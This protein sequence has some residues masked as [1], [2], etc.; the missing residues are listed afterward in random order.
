MKKIFAIL[1][2]ALL[3][4]NYVM[5][6][7]VDIT[8][9]AEAELTIAVSPANSGYVTVKETS[10]QDYSG[11]ESWER[12]SATNKTSVPK[13][14]TVS[15][16]FLGGGSGSVSATANV[17]G[18]VKQDIGYDFFGFGTTASDVDKGRGNNK[19]NSVYEYVVS[20]ECTCTVV[21]ILG[22]VIGQSL[23]ASDIKSESIYAIF[24]P[25]IA[26]GE[27]VDGQMDYSKYIQSGD[28]KIV[29]N[30][31]Q[32]VTVERTIHLYNATDYAVTT[33]E[34][35]NVKFKLSKAPATSGEDNVTL[36]IQVLPGATNGEK[37]SITFTS[38]NNGATATINVTVEAPPTITFD[39]PTV[40]GCGYQAVQQNISGVTYK[41]GKK[42][43]EY[44]AE[45][46]TV[47]VKNQ[48]DKQFVLTAYP[49]A[50][51]RF[52]RWKITNGDDVKYLYKESEQ[53]YEAK[54]D[55]HITA[56]FVTTDYAIFMVKDDNGSEIL[57]NNL[58]GACDEASRKNNKIV[59]VKQSGKVKA[60]N[61]TIPFGVTLLVPGD[62]AN[63][64]LTQTSSGAGSSMYLTGTLPSLHECKKYISLD[65]GTNITVNGAICV[66][67]KLG[68][69]MG[70][71]GV[72][73]DHGK[74]IMGTNSQ[75]VLES[76]SKLFAYG[77]I[78]G[79]GQVTA[80]SGANLYECVQIRDWRGGSA[81][82]SIVGMNG[83]GDGTKVFPFGQYYVQ[84]IETN[85]VLNHGATA[86]ISTA[87]NM[88]G[89]GLIPLNVP[90]IRP[91]VSGVSGM[92]CMQS[93]A[94]VK[95]WY[96]SEKDQL[97]IEF[98][99]DNIIDQMVLP[100]SIKILIEMDL[101]ISS[102]DYVLPFNSNMSFNLRDA[103]LV[104]KK[105]VLFF[106]GTIIDIDANSTLTI[107]KNMYLYDLDQFP[108]EE[109]KTFFFQAPTDMN[110]LP[111]TWTSTGI[112]PTRTR[113][114]T[115][116]TII[117]DGQVVV[118]GALY[119]TSGG[120]NITSHEGGKVVYNAVG[121]SRTTNQKWQ[122]PNASDN[123][124]VSNIT[125][126]I[127]NAKLHNDITKYSGDEYVTV[128]GTGT[129]TYDAT[130]GRWASDAE[131]G[132]SET[133]VPTFEM[134]KHA[135][136]TNTLSGE[137][138]CTFYKPNNVSFNTN[139][140]NVVKTSG[141]NFTIGTW[142]LKS[143]GKLYIP[144]TYTQQNKHGNYEAVFTLTDNHEKLDLNTPI[145]VTAIE[146]YQ[147]VFTTPEEFQIS[148]TVNV[149]KSPIPTISISPEKDNIAEQVTNEFMSWS[150]QLENEDGTAYQGSEFTFEYGTGMALLSNAKVTFTPNSVG[151]K[152]A[153][154]HLIATYDEDKNAE[155]PN[156]VAFQEITLIGNASLNP[157][158]LAFEEFTT[159]FVGDTRTL[160]ADMGNHANSTTQLTYDGTYA[161]IDIAQNKI[162]ANKAGTITV[163]ATQTATGSHESADKSIKITIYPTEQWNW[164]NLYYGSTHTNPVT[165][166]AASWT[167][168]L[169][170]DNSNEVKALV[171]LRQDES[172]NYIVTIGEPANVS[173]TL[174]AKFTF[175]SGGHTSTYTATLS[176]LRHLPACVDNQA[177]YNAVEYGRGHQ[178]ETNFIKNV[179]FDDADDCLSFTSHTAETSIWTMQFLG[180][181][182]KITFT[183]SGSR[184]WHFEESADALSWADVDGVGPRDLVS[185]QEV[186]LPLKP[187]TRFVRITYS[188]GEDN[189]GTLKNLCVTKLAISAS[190]NKLYLP[191]SD[192]LSKTIKLTHVQNTKPAISVLP[193]EGLNYIVSDPVSRDGVYETTVTLSATVPQEY[194]LTA[195]E[196]GAEA[197]VTVV[198]Y[199]FPQGLPIKS[200][201]WTGGK[202]E[203]YYF[204]AVE[205]SYAA[206][207]A[208][209]N[210]IVLQ[211]PSADHK[212]R[213]ITFAFEGG[214]S[215]VSFTFSAE[216]N[217]SEWKIEESVDGTESS[218]RRATGTC[219][220]NE[221][222]LIQE[223]DYTT[224]YVRLTY[225]GGQSWV[226]RY[227]TNLVIEGYPKV[228]ITP[229][230]LELNETDKEKT[231]VITAINLQNINLQ[232][233][234]DNFTL[235]H[236]S[237]NP[238]KSISLTQ[239]SGLYPDALG[240]NK[241]GDITITVNWVG[242]SIV[243]AGEI[244]I[245]NPDDNNA[246]LGTVQLLGAKSAITLD[247]ADKTGIWT[248]VPDGRAEGRPTSTEYTLEGKQFAAY[249]YRPIDVSNAFLQDASRAA[250]FD[251]LFVYGET[252]TTDGRTTITTPTQ[253]S[254]SN[255]Q[256]PYYIYKK[257]VDGISYEFVEAVENANSP[258]KTKLN[259][260]DAATTTDDEG[261]TYYSIKP[262]TGRTEMS[263]YVTGFCPYATTGYTKYDEG[264]WYIQGNA[265]QH[266]HLYLEDCHIYSRNKTEDG[267]NFVGRQGSAFTEGYVR[268]S[269][270]VFVFE[271][272]TKSE[273][274]AE[275][276]AFHVSIHTRGDNVL[277]SNYGSFFNLMGDLRAFQVSSPIQVHL[278]SD[279]YVNSSKVT[280]NFDDVWQVANT[281][282]EELDYIRTNGFLSLQ[283]Q[284]NNAP[285]IDLGNE[286]TTVNFR[287]GRI[288]LQNA[289]IVSTN[290]KTTLAISH[291]SG[292]MGAVGLNLHLAYGMGTDATGGT[293]KFY[294]GTT[295]VISMTVPEEYRGYYLMDT[296]ETGA[297]TAT[298][299][300]LRCPKQTYVYGGSHGMLRA[301]RSVTSRGG[302]PTDGPDGKALGKYE[303]TLITPEEGTRDEIK[304]N[305]LAIIR[306][307][308]NTGLKAYYENAPGYLNET[309]GLQSVAPIENKLYFWIPE[310]YG[311]DVTPERDATLTTWRTCM[312]EISASYAGKTAG[313]G[314][315]LEIE[316]DEVV[317][318]LLYCQIDKNIHDVI[319]KTERRTVTEWVDEDEDGE[320]DPGEEKSVEKDVH[321]YEAMVKDPTGQL[322]DDY[323]SIRPTEVGSELQNAVTNNS[324]Y[325][326]TDRVYYITTATADTWMNFTAP[327]DVE[328]IYVMETYDEA[329]IV[330]Y[331][332]N[333]DPGDES[334]YSMTAKFQA[335]HNADFAA[336]FAMAMALGSD[337]PFEHIYNQYIEW[338]MLQDQYTGSVENYTTRGMT[339]LVHYDGTN[340][341]TSHFYLYEN[342]TTAD[343][344]TQDVSTFQTQWEI[345]PEKSNRKLLEKGNTYSMLFPYALGVDMQSE[346]NFWDYWTGKFLIFESTLGSQT[347]PH[348]IDGSDEA[349]QELSA[350]VEE[351]HAKLSGNK[352]LAQFNTEREDVYLYNI[353]RRGREQYVQNEKEDV[354][355][356]S[357]NADLQVFPTIEPTTTFLIVNL[358]DDG[359]GQN[360][361]PAR[362]I[363]RTGQIIYDTTGEGNGTITGGNIPTVGGG[364]DLFITKTTIGINI[365]VA[366]PQQVRVIS[367]T[368]AVLYSGMVQTSVDVAIPTTG[369]YVVTG[370][371]EAQ[372]ILY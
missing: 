304:D 122:D 244:T 370:E 247:D 157:N 366:A 371:N 190:T 351:N 299:S 158:N 317:K 17:Y 81:T 194:T 354:Y 259:F 217:L 256:T 151:E 199:T 124:Q 133:V 294:D 26:I 88:T 361:A 323:F 312:T 77:Y 221:T 130:Q 56:E 39:P 290:Y 34:T 54:N 75:I 167:L 164:S 206:W 58:Q 308:P 48:D 76:G 281:T 276:E 350:S 293:V 32:T 335:E 316:S 306:N 94:T 193:A 202:Q 22:S 268:G 218:W 28:I 232:V 287:G 292:T 211:N 213:S 16:N 41:L 201:D 311:Y 228:V 19:E 97:Y 25:I 321:V 233:D 278:A 272:L 87:V 139:D 349:L 227:V 252:T 79:S 187:T 210:R 243:N 49:S 170:D 153:V 241:V 279:K 154:L 93:N 325:E 329:K 231:F 284:V 184:K 13:S 148:S 147:P 238:A 239:S 216:I 303:Y 271:C 160:F 265:G 314:G 340:F 171:D 332:A 337:K 298:T 347:A 85:L 331:F 20:T 69:E 266:V 38:K 82:T 275:A 174:T 55:D 30:P 277:K 356:E 37:A 367:S 269:G 338:A 262:A 348:E 144:I 134:K 112:A 47:V 109:G 27:L 330:E 51:H 71:N 295:S 339:P 136:S 99:G 59:Y 341:P 315:D 101:T 121:N 220:V 357:T 248:G 336:F 254:G 291:R 57:F 372:K 188:A 172:G 237:S 226:E 74:I 253:E 162:T 355:D 261:H 72:P 156:L 223:L 198:A 282:K 18:Y 177:R 111:L 260:A 65:E 219:T 230:E 328:N 179:V 185:D 4:V 255:A 333:V 264:V 118:K 342:K 52:Y 196:N 204:Y 205:S 309:Y 168:A 310:N 95:K 224:R 257:G 140:F 175:T 273:N 42:L 240:V 318:Y 116:A 36:T 192:G 1:V 222:S 33:Q 235:K 280:L 149:A 181:P 250:I 165:T 319:S 258:T 263:I 90:F 200:S 285:S 104:T 12:I 352:S 297:E 146:N 189:V 126:N 197:D 135:T 346:R 129:Y 322:G 142:E 10:L 137:I 86:Y 327:F 178:Y 105:D 89:A 106:P 3:S 23:S 113:P 251:Y 70:F 29:S 9:T 334:K 78:T 343:W 141:D 270:G 84:N 114:T 274:I 203:Y 150:Y 15:S 320:I 301:C 288:E 120:A 186:S 159:M 110:I 326:V 300:C 143:D 180:T 61:Y 138:V 344:E 313:I 209:N 215:I 125:I 67:A 359:S 73:F 11:Y 83:Q 40:D 80:N 324:S 35:S 127:T 166:N 45:S 245:T 63:T 96:D 183:P 283:K 131:A 155:T 60:E 103:N 353:P 212:D 14:K 246:V 7:S 360:L 43:A 50:N 289:A 53:P 364:N 305:G 123:T 302:A 362:R 365:A 21:F 46:K 296:D 117:V 208:T 107:E 369:V 345:V 363:T 8:A 307:F 267:N 68:G 108:P 169:A 368:G 98:T 229:S 214:P 236:G 66:Y 2:G 5:G 286:H 62:D 358:S 100:L 6:G 152:R 102:G 31:A 249:T 176:G 173:N 132:I 191:I 115:D 182:D 44:S 163:Q 128:S 64:C 234:N 242:T 92:V 195:I 207:D 91:Y 225:N 145:R 24:K 161:T 119:T